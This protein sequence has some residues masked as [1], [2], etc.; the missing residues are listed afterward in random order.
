[1]RCQLLLWHPKT[2]QRSLFSLAAPYLV[3][4]HSKMSQSVHPNLPQRL[5]NLS[6]LPDSGSALALHVLRC[7]PENG[8]SLYSVGSSE[9]VPSGCG[10][11]G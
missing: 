10:F 11:S 4:K 9:R 8:F 1:M 6:F 2:S 3:N 7:S 5:S